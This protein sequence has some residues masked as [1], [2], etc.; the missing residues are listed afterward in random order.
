[1]IKAVNKDIL[2]II[3]IAV[4]AFSLRAPA[5][6]KA[7]MTDEGKI[8]TAVNG[9]YGMIPEFLIKT[10]A[11]P[12]LYYYFSKVWR[13]VSDARWWMRFPNIIFGS[14]TA[15]VLYLAARELFDTRIARLAGFITAL[16]PNLVFISETLRP[17]SMATFLMSLTI[18]FFIRYFMRGGLP[19]LLLYAV[20]AA[21]SAY[22]YYFNILVIISLNLFLFIKLRSIK[23][24]RALGLFAASAAAGALFLPWVP[25]MQR[26]MAEAL[27]DSGSY[28][29]LF[30]AKKFGAYIGNIHVGAMMRG[31]LGAFQ[32]DNAI[33]TNIRLHAHL[34]KALLLVLAAGVTIIFGYL[35]WKSRK[36]L[37]ESESARGATALIITIVFAPLLLAAILKISMGFEI[38][39]RYM[40]PLAVFSSIIMA[41]FILSFN[42]KIYVNSLV[43]I[44]A[45]FFVMRIFCIWG[46]NDKDHTKLR[47]YIT[48]DGRSKVVISAEP[49]IF[50]GAPGSKGLKIIEADK[51]YVSIKE[52]LKGEE[53]FYWVEF[54][55]PIAVIRGSSGGGVIRKGL[56][57]DYRVADTVRLDDVVSVY[58]YRKR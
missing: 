48:N 16:S 10:E 34:D 19:Y 44:L 2:A 50:K 43:V 31:I 49:N 42:K 52:A 57:G 29:Q 51:G 36:R 40:G 30:I 20:S 46:Y 5:I 27:S 4:L 35:I 58:L 9:S 18:L 15:L 41:G 3:F 22:T 28:G 54:N 55:T 7:L 37:L 1:M 23:F 24:A 45:G 33:F 14:L 11:H 26:Q 56:E 6:N 12:P 8:Y 25:Y 47:D 21:L 53:S 38:L 32:I 39:Q 17:Y 13:G